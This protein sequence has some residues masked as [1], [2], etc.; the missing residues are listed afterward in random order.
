MTRLTGLQHKTSEQQAELNDSRVKR[1]MTD[2]EKIIKWFENRNP[3]DHPNSLLCSLSLGLTA[4]VGDGVNC[5]EEEV[6]GMTYS[7]K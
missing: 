7:S 4:D 5:D 3:F 1:D 2:Q 6:I